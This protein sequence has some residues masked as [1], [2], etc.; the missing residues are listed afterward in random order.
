MMQLIRYAFVGVLNTGLGYAV[1]FLCMG[2][3]DWSP[4]ASNVAGYAVGFVVSFV[5]NRSFT[6]RST[7][8]A[9]GELKR[10]L[11]IFA[12]AY[13]ANLAVLVL[14]VHAAGMGGGWAQ[15]VAGIVY[16]A[17]SFVLNKYYVFVDGV[18]HRS[19]RRPDHV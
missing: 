1:I 2:V 4:V 13:L 9:R 16:F 15:V 12:L 8:A 19:R 3:F 6:F 17:L 7:G 5:L 10:F 11:L 18:E 14:L